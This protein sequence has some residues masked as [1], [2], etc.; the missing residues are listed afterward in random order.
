ML[1]KFY[2]KKTQGSIDEDDL[3]LSVMK[4]LWKYEQIANAM[5][6]YIGYKQSNL[7]LFIY[8]TLYNIHKL[9]V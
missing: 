2:S 4:R 7:N 9:I 1:E 3:P 5:H 8:I 6:Y